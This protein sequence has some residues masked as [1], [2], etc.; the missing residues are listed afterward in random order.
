MATISRINLSRWNSLLILILLVA[1]IVSVACASDAGTLAPTVTATPTAASTAALAPTTAPT[2]AAAL[3]IAPTQ[4]PPP[5]ANHKEGSSDD[6]I[7]VISSRAAAAPVLSDIS[8]I[9]RLGDVSPSPIAQRVG[10]DS[11]LT[12]SAKG[13]VTAEA[14]EAYVV[15]TSEPHFGPS[16]PQP[17]SSEDRAKV[18]ENLAQLGIKKEDIEFDSPLR[19]P[20]A[21]ISV[22]VEPTDL[23]EIGEQ[24][25]DAVENVLRLRGPEASGL[26]FSL[27][28]ENCARVLALARR[29][30]VPEATKSADDLA[31]ALGLRRGG[32]IGA[33]EYPLSNFG[34]NP[35]GSDECG[36]SG[37]FGDPYDPRLLPFDAEA[38]TEV[39][40]NLQVSYALE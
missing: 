39:S 29:A 38:K 16:G 3:T 8:D 17:M 12:V 28:E 35:F 36:S 6:S 24:I 34:F 25:Q 40:V 30:A 37:Q 2:E 11:G 19:P 7:R 10:G 27:S 22:E 31:A 21:G 14:D 26:R 18:I 33:V 23:P 1:A 5:L 9:A 20:F 32:V 15:I 4:A 13:S